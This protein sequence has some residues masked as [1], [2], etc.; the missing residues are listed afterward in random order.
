MPQLDLLFLTLLLTAAR[1]SGFVAFLPL[2]GSRTLPKTV[3]IGL[4]VTL[5]V[6][7]GFS[8]SIGSSSLGIPSHNPGWFTLAWLMARELTLGACCGYVL[9]LILVPARIAGSYIAQE[10]GL[11]IATLTSSE[12]LGN[13][14]VLSE[15]LEGLAILALLLTNIHHLFFL[16]FDRMLAT[17]PIG[18]AWPFPRSD[19]LV[20][21][22]TSLPA[23]GV[24]MALPIVVV[25]G[26]TTIGLLFA[27]RQ[28]PQF[29]L[30][31]FGMP[32][33][34]VAGLIALFLFIP[35]LIYFFVN[36]IRHVM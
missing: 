6:V 22:L 27:M 13:Q 11:T 18:R 24:S 10:M 9:S 15:I 33:R 14:N 17:F 31:T 8:Q 30:F 34:L 23:D 32:V 4:V 2:F 29:N 25:L 3:K 12:G 7:W 36:S 20:M 19:W 28:T 21:Q 5:T 35:D 26:C 16:L 1:V